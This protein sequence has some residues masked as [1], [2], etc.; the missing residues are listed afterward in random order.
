MIAA[1]SVDCQ[2]DLKIG[3][4]DCKKPFNHVPVI[5]LVKPSGLGGYFLVTKDYVDNVYVTINRWD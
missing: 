5:C 3:T 2:E 4:V 1:K